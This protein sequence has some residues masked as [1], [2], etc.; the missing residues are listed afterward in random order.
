MSYTIASALLT[1]STVL[2]TSELSSICVGYVIVA[3]YRV[4][5]AD[6]YA[7]LNAARLRNCVLV[8]NDV[9]RRPNG[10]RKLRTTAESLLISI[11]SAGT[12]SRSLSCGTV[13]YVESLLIITRCG[14]LLVIRRS[15]SSIA[16]TKSGPAATAGS[17]RSSVARRAE[18]RITRIV[19]TG[20]A[21]RSVGSLESL[22]RWLL[23]ILQ[24]LEGLLQS[25]LSLGRAE[26]V[27]DGD[28]K[29][30]KKSFR[31]STLKYSQLN[32]RNRAHRELETTMKKILTK[33]N[34]AYRVERVTSCGRE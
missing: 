33:S 21:T 19:D 30:C 24:S 2:S 13:E 20:T 23:Q 5:S 9:Q 29:A 18:V 34:R 3:T 1:S 25:S 11:G 4:V 14:P 32:Y 27:L 31:P 16:T 12:T 10:G 17:R 6:S 7:P 22:L 8:G 28:Q 26:D 15:R